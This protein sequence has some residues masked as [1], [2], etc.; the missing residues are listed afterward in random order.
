MGEVYLAR[1]THLGRKVALKLVKE[2]VLDS[3]EAVDRFMFE[4]RATAAINHPN[5]VTVYSVGEHVSRPYV[6]LEYIDGQ[7]LLRRVGKN[8]PGYRDVL[9]IGQAIAEALVA[10]HAHGVTHRDLKPQNILI[11]QQGRPRVVDFGLA[12]TIEGRLPDEQTQLLRDSELTA[13]R[14]LDPL[15]DGVEGTP[16][17]MSPEQWQGLPTS[18]RTDIWALG[19]ILCELLTGAHPYDGFPNVAMLAIQVCGTEPTPLPSADI[20][21]AMRLLLSDCLDKR[22]DRRPTAKQVE[23]RLLTLSRKLSEQNLDGHP[24]FLGLQPFSEQQSHLFFGREA[25][26]DACV[27]QLQSAPSLIAIGPSGAGKS[28]L[29]NA[30]VIPRLRDQSPHLVLNMRPGRAPFRSLARRILDRAPELAKALSAGEQPLADTLRLSTPEALTSGDIELARRTAIAE[31]ET[32]PRGLRAP[33]AQ[34]DTSS[35]EAA[36]ASFPGILP[37]D[38][39]TVETSSPIARL[40]DQLREAPHTLNLVLNELAERHRCRVLLFVDALEELHAQ[41]AEPKERERFLAAICAAAD[42]PSQPVR[43]VVTLREEFIS[44]LPDEPGLRDLLRRVQVVRTPGPRALEQILTRPLEAVG[45]GYDDPSLVS[46]IVDQLSNE[47]AGLALLQF[48]AR[49]LWES[50]DTQRRLLARA[51]YDAMGGIAGALA[52]HAD[53]VL[54]G[55]STPQVRV[56]RTL[57]T[58]LITSDRTRR[59]LSHERLLE[60]LPNEAN[61]V[62]DRFVAA[63]LLTAARGDVFAQSSSRDSAFTSSEPELDE[64][65]GDEELE[66][67]HE[68]LIVNW[69]RLRRWVD[70]DREEIA[71]LGEIEQAAAMWERRQKRPNALWGADELRQARRSLRRLGS[72]LPD[73]LEAFLRASERNARRKARRRRLELTGAATLLVGITAIA[74][75]AAVVV[76][77]QAKEVE[78]QRRRAIAQRK[79]AQARQKEAVRQQAAAELEGA[80]AALAHGR[81]LESRTKLRAALEK[82]DEPLGRLLWARLRQR[83]LLWSKLVGSLANA[84]A[85]SPDGKLLAVGCGDRTVRLIDVNAAR[86]KRALRGHPD[87][88]FAVTF[89]PDGR[90]LASGAWDGTLSLWSMRHHTAPRLLRGHKGGIWALAYDRKGTRLASASS[91]KTVRVWDV[92]SGRSTLLLRGFRRGV[93]SVAFSPKDRYVAAGGADGTVILWPA[94]GGVPLGQRS[95]GSSVRSIAFHPSEPMLAAAD[96]RGAVALLSVPKLRVLARHRVHRAGVHAV[97]FDKA[98]TRLAT[99]GWDRSVKVFALR[100]WQ[101]SA[102]FAGHNAG[103]RAVIFGAHGNRVYSASADRSVRAW[104]LGKKPRVD[105]ASSARHTLSAHRDAIYG[106]AFS[107]DGQT[108]ASAGYDRSVLLWD[109]VSGQPIRRFRGHDGPVYGVG[110]S[111]NGKEVVTG[112]WDKTVRVFD[113][114][115]AAQRLTLRGHKGGIWSVVFSPDGKRIASASAD[116]S[117]RLWD[118]DR[119]ALLHALFGHRGAVWS[120]RFARD[121]K[122]LVSG[123]SDRSIRIWS[124]S[125]RLLRTLKGHRAAVWSVNRYAK[126]GLL[127]AG[128]DKTVR[129]WTINGAQKPVTVLSMPHRIYSAALQPKGDLL[130]ISPGAVGA[131]DIFS[132]QQKRLVVAIEAPSP[133]AGTVAFSPDGKTLAVPSRDGSLRLFDTRG[134]RQWF[135]RGL[136]SDRRAVWHGT[137][138]GWR[139]VF[140]KAM[141]RPRWLA[142]SGKARQVAAHGTRL[143]VL[144]GSSLESWDRRDGRLLWRREVSLALVREGGHVSAPF[145]P[146]RLLA[147]PSG[148]LVA[149]QK[150]LTWFDRS[151]LRRLAGPTSAI[152]PLGDQ[153][154]LVSRGILRRIRLGFGAAEQLSEL[155]IGRASALLPLGRKVLVGR[156]DGSVDTLDGSARPSQTLPSVVYSAVT[157][158]AAGPAKTLISGHRNGVVCLRDIQSGRLLGKWRAVG[159]IERI[160]LAKHRVFAASDT[161]DLLVQDLSILRRDYCALIREIWRWVP[162][163]WRGG[164]AGPAGPPAGHRCGSR[165]P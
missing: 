106:V 113:V 151:S 39:A 91:D 49:R 135:T 51:D 24:P 114:A 124:E 87:Q 137:H 82:R 33:P 125:G 95:L 80:R 40:A 121:G 28:S 142:Q 115:T 139:Q 72:A 149:T 134:R 12:A 116:S 15:K 74:V 23:S 90:E 58:R 53:S 132:L 59:S 78:R 16:R 136:I 141:P 62:L 110:F 119:G 20:P 152:A 25:E 66:L 4:A 34:Q 86:Q 164:Y 123:S 158:I 3:D 154:L 165:R 61:E 50:R 93:R 102:D 79:Q 96:G 6:A 44:R 37:S 161:G 75:A 2:G 41:V 76:N 13:L 144:R 65:D 19:L 43:L 130:A 29:I 128:W 111:P 146:P 57:L 148:C 118:S 26:I 38:S 162:T 22:T 160:Q 56:A 104:Q 133:N 145:S 64:P 67:V 83:P 21:D 30:G 36:Y 127:S 9:R 143:C 70:E 155:R 129:R 11:D 60:G 71:L 63:R 7:T 101:Q 100:P 156:P 81:M 27:E 122:Q 92:E 109:A 84:L 47:R 153:L 45:Y 77:R 14:H 54:E 55:L 73:R 89:S 32:A 5:V 138:R 42:E 52:G 35:R 88:V 117:V 46:E 69:D 112:S 99:A 85:L 159:G 147:V 131:V 68:S 10:A 150:Q 107:P 163:I 1:D 157:A 140:G 97:V 126:Q 105:P 108:V 8:R 120:I 98:G 31:R 94:K 18:D 103:V 48:A 17:Y